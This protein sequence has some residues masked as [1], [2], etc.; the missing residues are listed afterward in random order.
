M[1]YDTTNLVVSWLPY[2]DVSRAACVYPP[3]DAT[4]KLP[5]FTWKFASSR[6]PSRCVRT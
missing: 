5:P 6:L 4:L 1:L 2:T 3:A